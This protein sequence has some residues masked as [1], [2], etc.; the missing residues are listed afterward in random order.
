MFNVNSNLFSV[1]PFYSDQRIKMD[2]YMHT[3]F[4]NVDYFE[5][6]FESVNNLI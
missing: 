6:R 5:A 3:K 4:E 1:S 2:K